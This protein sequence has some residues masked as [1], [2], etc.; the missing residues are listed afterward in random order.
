MKIPDTSVFLMNK[1]VFKV[2]LVL[3]LIFP[4]FS[5]AGENPTVKFIV[6]KVEIKRESQKKWI[7]AKLKMK[8][9]NNDQLRTSRESKAILEYPDGTSVVV[10]ENSHIFVSGFTPGSGQLS[11]RSITTFFGGIFVKVKKTQD[12]KKVTRV[13]TPTSVVAVRGTAFAVL[14]DAKKNYETSV[15]VLSGVVVVK[16]IVL[17][18]EVFV[19]GGDKMA[20]LVN[21]PPEKIE[22]VVQE[23]VDRLAKW[24][25]LKRV[26]GEIDLE[27][28][29]QSR[30]RAII[31]GKVKNKL[32]IFPFQ[33]RS[34][35]KSKWDIKARFSE[36]VSGEL[37]KVTSAVVTLAD[38]KITD[39]EKMIQYGKKAKATILLFGQIEKFEFVKF[40]SLSARGNNYSEMLKAHVHLSLF[41]MDLRGGQKFRKIKVVREVI[42]KIKPRLSPQ[43][44]LR[45]PFSFS[46]EKFRES[47]LGKA[48]NLILEDIKAEL[49]E[50]L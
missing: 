29:A 39:Q 37:K 19:R 27:R 28:R 21:E 25:G 38:Q 13:F 10:K 3:F 49:S 50:D 42:Q 34:G 30:R 17:P 44:V 22:P 45:V 16:N 41:T 31:S 46:E 7:F 20:V 5:F 12:G 14:V 18:E 47:A 26:K 43:A 24:V 9:Q 1:P 35:F 36:L 11:S 15:Q 8:L 6:G 48:V 40:G 23:D 32:V 4:F 33:D 2:F